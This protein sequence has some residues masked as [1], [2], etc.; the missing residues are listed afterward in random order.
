[1][2]TMI[3]EEQ[4]KMTGIKKVKEKILELF[5]YIILIAFCIFLIYLGNL[6]YNRLYKKSIN[7]E[8]FQKHFYADIK[9]LNRIIEAVQKIPQELALILEF[10]STN[11]N[12]I[13]ILLKSVLFNNREIFGSAIAFEPFQYNK[14]SLY[15][16]PYTYRN[17]VSIIHTNLNDSIYHYFY[18]DW[19]LVPKTLN[20]PT[21]SEPYYDT[22]GGKILMSTYSVPFYKFDGFEEEFNGIVTVDVSVEKLTEATKLMGKFFNGYVVLISE[23]GTILAAPF[24]DWIYNETIFTLASDKNLPFLRDIGRDLINGKSGIK[25]IDEFETQKNLIAFY[26]IVRANKCG[27]IL[28]FPENELYK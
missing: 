17:G 8:L 10:H 15:Y 20:K 14:D 9:Q 23:H 2:I 5:F 7:T 12:E 6:A 28:F 18:K 27:L 3:S 25:H 13:K 21:W 11:D 24:K 26:S 4:N 19:Y 22:G 1:M 16:A